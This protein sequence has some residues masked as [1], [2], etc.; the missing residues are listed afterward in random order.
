M[1][2]LQGKSQHSFSLSVNGD[3]PTISVNDCLGRTPP[4]ERSPH[5]DKTAV[6]GYKGTIKSTH[7]QKDTSCTYEPQTKPQVARG[8]KGIR[9]LSS[10]SIQ[11]EDSF[12]LHCNDSSDESY[13]PTKKKTPKTVVHEATRNGSREQ[14]QRSCRRSS[15]QSSKDNSQ[16]QPATPVGSQGRTPDDGRGSSAV[17]RPSIKTASARKKP[18]PAVPSSRKRKAEEPVH[19][20]PRQVHKEGRKE[21]PLHQTLK[22]NG[23]GN[24]QPT[25]AILFQAQEGELEASPGSSSCQEDDGLA[26]EN[27]LPPSGSGFEDEG[28]SEVVVSLP[29]HT[30]PKG[31]DR[32]TGMVPDRRVHDVGIS[33]ITPA[34]LEEED[35]RNHSEKLQAPSPLAE[36]VDNMEGSGPEEREGECECDVRELTLEFAAICKVCYAPIRS[37]HKWTKIGH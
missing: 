2:H 17:P 31:Q 5:A 36:E 26:K 30:R 16:V 37:T 13:L 35:N 27:A 3:S 21:K 14:P 1:L 7:R 6:T 32:L 28:I 29:Y 11:S 22:G 12:N 19:A 34:G 25:Q 23:H 20:P 8:R 4:L 18:T 24:L 15:E 10:F 9:A 33:P